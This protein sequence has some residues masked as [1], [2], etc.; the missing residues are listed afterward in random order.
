[1]AITKEKKIEIVEKL[2]KLI[3]SAKSLVFVNFHGL[4]VADVTTLRK[5]LRAENI[6]YIVSK[7]T[8]L[9]RAFAEKKF[10]GEIP[11]LLGEIALVYGNDPLAPSREIYNFHK[12][13]KETIKIVG[14]VFEGKYMDGVAMLRIATIPSREVLLA[15]FVNL[16]NSPIQR[17]ATAL[18]QIAV[19]KETA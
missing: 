18:N 12:D 17:F 10:E 7:K 14:G 4:N 5:K 2:K 3:N 15:Q 9:T 1:M 8:L 6:G 19:K 13:H 16:I 11:A